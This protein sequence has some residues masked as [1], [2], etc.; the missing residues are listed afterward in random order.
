MYA[1]VSVSEGPES[2]L[3]FTLELGESIIQSG[4]L[5]PERIR[6]SAEEEPGSTR[7]ASALTEANAE[8][9]TSLSAGDELSPC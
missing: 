2:R 7:L 8:G 1:N 3:G 9:V 5:T 6:R 4:V